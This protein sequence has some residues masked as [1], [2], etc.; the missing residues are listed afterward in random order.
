MSVA[1]GNKTHIFPSVPE[2]SSEARESGIVSNTQ[3]QMFG[4][5]PAINNPAATMGGGTRNSIEWMT[6]NDGKTLQ[7]TYRSG[8]SR[9]ADGHDGVADR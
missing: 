7:E 1:P 3:R 9:S 5:S 2:N 4:Q 6:H 8:L